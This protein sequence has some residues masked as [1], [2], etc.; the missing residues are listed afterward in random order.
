MRRRSMKF[1]IWDRLDH[2]QS[3]VTVTGR[4]TDGELVVRRHCRQLSINVAIAAILFGW[5]V[6]WRHCRQQSNCQ[7]TV[8]RFTIDISVNGRPRLNVG[9]HAAAAA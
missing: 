7:L 5:V 9:A 1:I 3:T 6:V 8:K 2:F 4:F